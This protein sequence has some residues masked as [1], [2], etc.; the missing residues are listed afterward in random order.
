MRTLLASALLLPIAACGDSDAPPPPVAAAPA[1]TPAPSPAP[2]GSGG[3]VE[4]PAGE[5]SGTAWQL[6]GIT[7]T[8]GTVI[9]AD[10]AS[11]YQ[12]TFAADGNILIKADCNQANGLWVSTA[13][14]KLAVGG[15]VSTLAMCAP[16][17]LAPE[18]M[19]GLE[20]A[21]IYAFEGD[22]V[23]ITSAVGS[24]LLLMKI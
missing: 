11:R 10:D 24:S 16:E 5:L 14:G 21:T 2:L 17:S 18:F 6:V 15:M 20:G 19:A 12:V 22:A 23:R 3:T 7:K 1:P 8:D 9:E 4:L 13:P